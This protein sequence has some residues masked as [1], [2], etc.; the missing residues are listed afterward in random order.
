MTAD[1][2]L[3][4]HERWLRNDDPIALLDEKQHQRLEHV[5]ETS[6]SDDAIRRYSGIASNGITQRPG[7]KFRVPIV[8]GYRGQSFQCLG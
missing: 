2:Q 1:E 5:V 8:R 3:V 4:D 7:V 6:P